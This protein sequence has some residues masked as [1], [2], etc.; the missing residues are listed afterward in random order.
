MAATTLPQSRLA[1]EFDKAAA[2][3]KTL[4]DAASA[5]QMSDLDADSLAHAEDLMAGLL[6]LIGGA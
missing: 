5:R 4:G 6:P 1:D 3:A 2:R